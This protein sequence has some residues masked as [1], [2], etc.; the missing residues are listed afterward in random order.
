M[1]PMS[2][3]PQ[4]SRSYTDARLFEIVREAEKYAAEAVAAAETEIERRELQENDFPVKQEDRPFGKLSSI[5]E[6][7]TPPRSSHKPD[8]VIDWE[9]KPAQENEAGL[10]YL[11]YLM[12][13]SGLAGLF[14]FYNARTSIAYN[15]SYATSGGDPF[16]LIM[17]A[18]AFLFQIFLIYLLWRRNR[19]AFLLTAGFAAVGATSLLSLLLYKFK[20]GGLEILESM[21]AI[22]LVEGFSLL[23]S[24]GL[25][26]TLIWLVYREELRNT[27]GITK[28]KLLIA[29]ATGVGLGLFSLFRALNFN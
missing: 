11:R 28:D 12:I 24:I 4:R 3:F 13:V 29:L 20:A 9:D 17:Y 26:F 22:I 18:L 2:D 5:V 14:S 23:I 7:L 27:F 16:V 19:I 21:Q 10:R 25:T 15:L 8:D 6:D 1:K